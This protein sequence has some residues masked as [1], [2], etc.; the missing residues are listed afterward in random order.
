MT[1]WTHP[2]ELARAKLFIEEAKELE[3]Q[4]AQMPLSERERFICHGFCH[5]SV[6]SSVAHAEGWAN[7]I[8]WCAKNN[9]WYL[10]QGHAQAEPAK[11]TKQGLQS[12]AKQIGT[13]GNAI[14]RWNVIREQFALEQIDASKGIGQEFKLIIKVR[15]RLVHP[16]PYFFSPPGH[17]LSSWQEDKVGRVATSLLARKRISK[18]PI[19]DNTF[20]LIPYQL[21]SSDFAEWVARTSDEIVSVSLRSIGVP[22]GQ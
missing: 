1:A 8:L 3:V 4:H 18:S 14:D 13:N 21:L 5:A 7:L 9:L 6:I 16:E 17:G 22:V 12:A 15:N 20:A 10:W 11:A 2:D 19:Y